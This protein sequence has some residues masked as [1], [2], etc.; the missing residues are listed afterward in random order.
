[1]KVSAF[2]LTFFSGLLVL[3]CISLLGSAAPTGLDWTPV[4]GDRIPD[5]T[6]FTKGGELRKP[7]NRMRPVEEVRRPQFAPDTN[8]K[9][10]TRPVPMWADK[11]SDSQQGKGLEK[12]KQSMRTRVKGGW[13]S[14][15]KS[16]SKAAKW[17]KSKGRNCWRCRHLDR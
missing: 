4:P 3:F 7:L 6:Y 5:P 10:R 15:N 16:F 2:S 8:F 9:E 13:S 12:P 17:L 14:M 11:L 1:M